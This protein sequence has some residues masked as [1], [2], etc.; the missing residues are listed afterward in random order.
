[1]IQCF[2]GMCG[3][4]KSLH[5]TALC[6]TFLKRGDLVLTNYPLNVRNIKTKKTIYYFYISNEYLQNPIVLL[7][8]ITLYLKSYPKHRILVVI[9][10][11][12]TLFDSRQWNSKNRTKWLEFFAT[13]RHLNVRSD[14]D[15]LNIIMI[16]QSMDNLDKRIRSITEYQVKHLNIANYRTFGFLLGCIFGSVILYKKLWNNLKKDNVCETGLL[17][18]T[19]KITCL[20]NT[21]ECFDS[22]LHNPSL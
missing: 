22:Q 15:V 17:L 14:V 8:I 10:E 19:K 12:H 21:L 5:A 20:Y 4:G 3:S 18:P 11:A 2:S 7:N 9:D 1:M 16:T 6:R 13:H